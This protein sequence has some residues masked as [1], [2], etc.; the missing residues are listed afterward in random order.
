[1][2]EHSCDADVS[3]GVPHACVPCV[4][5]VKPPVHLP[6]VHSAEDQPLH[7]HPLQKREEC[8]GATQGGMVSAGE[9]QEQGSQRGLRASRLHC[10][11][12]PSPACPPLPHSPL[13]LPPIWQSTPSGI[14]L[15]SPPP[16]PNPSLQ[17]IGAAEAAASAAAAEPPLS[18]S[19]GFGCIAKAASHVRSLRVFSP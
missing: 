9:C 15:S 2:V 11:E 5:D 19:R 6:A 7:P 18:G 14:Q 16:L 8:M 1:M 17:G 4:A 12:E 3:G 13:Q 10:W